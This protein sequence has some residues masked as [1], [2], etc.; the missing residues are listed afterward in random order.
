MDIGREMSMIKTKNNA[1][2]QKFLYNWAKGYSKRYE[3]TF[4]KAQD[5]DQSRQAGTNPEQCG[6]FF[7]LLEECY[8]FMEDENGEPVTAD[9]VWNMDEVG[10]ERKV[11]NTLT[12]VS[13]MKRGRVR[14]IKG[15]HQHITACGAVNAGGDK[16]PLHF[17]LKGSRKSKSMSADDDIS[18]LKGTEPGEGK[19]SVQECGY[20]DDQVW[21]NEYT[22]QLIEGMR[23]TLPPQDRRS[24]WQLLILDGFLSHVRMYKSLRTFRE[25][26]IL[27]LCLPSHTSADLQPLDV[28]IFKPFKTAF[29]QHYHERTRSNMAD[30]GRFCMSQQEVPLLC[31]QAW[32]S[33]A[34][35]SNCQSAFKASGIFPF[36]PNFVSENPSIFTPSTLFRTDLLPEV[37]VPVAGECPMMLHDLASE[38]ILNE[39]FN[40]ACS[41]AATAF[42][43]VL[44]NSSNFQSPAIQ[45]KVKELMRL[46]LVQEAAGEYILAAP[47]GIEGK[48]KARRAKK[49]DELGDP[50]NIPKILNSEERLRRGD[51]LTA[52]RN[53]SAASKELIYKQRRVESIR[54]LD[55]QRL[56]F[57]LDIITWDPLSTP[58]GNKQPRLLTSV[59]IGDIFKRLAELP[60][61]I[62]NLSNRSA[63]LKLTREDKMRLIRSN[64]IDSENHNEPELTDHTI[65]PDDMKENL[66]PLRSGRRGTKRKRGCISDSEDSANDDDDEEEDDDDDDD[67]AEDGEGEDEEEDG[68]IDRIADASDDE[69]EEDETFG[70]K[71]QE[72]LNDRMRSRPVLVS[73]EVDQT[74][75]QPNRKNAIPDLQKGKRVRCVYIDDETGKHTLLQF[76]ATI[77]DVEDETCGVR[78]DDDALK[79]TR[80]IQI[81]DVKIVFNNPRIWKVGDKVKANYLGTVS[82][83]VSKNKH[84]WYAGEVAEVAINDLGVPMYHIKYVDGDDEVTFAEYLMPLT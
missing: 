6:H 43:N 13:T 83:R 1:K 84:E 49:R 74:V 59:A 29:E 9:K 12:V 37:T 64:F 70:E 39:T 54:E 63:F 31:I 42:C 73:C 7:K 52:E 47:N 25:S 81:Q 62:K 58:K 15:T 28:A 45:G 69:G 11:N 40:E 14:L 78:Y 3:I 50:F 5:W 80:T 33:A 79:A 34:T 30:F 55:I 24:K 20:M 4:K 66:K 19:Y 67:D 68:T 61:D 41:A 10:I 44:K 38:I 76:L 27:L 60:G 21:E 18:R 53:S 51:S 65:I 77:V 36:Q 22:P 71:F 72:N 32:N 48:I 56:A 26:K 75:I 23:K 2:N 57:A 46:S 82:A 16:I 17:I 35:P 8:K